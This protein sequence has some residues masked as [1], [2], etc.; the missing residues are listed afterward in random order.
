MSVSSEGMREGASLGDEGGRWTLTSK[1]SRSRDGTLPVRQGVYSKGINPICSEWRRKT[2]HKDPNTVS[3]VVPTHQTD[4]STA[5]PR[6]RMELHDNFDPS[7]A[8]MLIARLR[9]IVLE[10]IQ[11]AMRHGSAGQQ[12]EGLV[13]GEVKLGPRIVDISRGDRQRFPFLPLHTF[14]ELLT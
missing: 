10:D 7:L 13:D 11:G 14:N 4:L 8:I 6:P 1:S 2:T 12:I 5:Q 9:D 3:S